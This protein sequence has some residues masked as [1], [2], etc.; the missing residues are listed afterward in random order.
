M[1]NIAFLK[2]FSLHSFKPLEAR[3]SPALLGDKGLVYLKN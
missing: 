2:E 3:D 1:E